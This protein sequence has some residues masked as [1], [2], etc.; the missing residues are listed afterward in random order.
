MLRQ[1]R[2]KTKY[3]LMANYISECLEKFRALPL[4]IQEAV[5][6]FEALQVIDKLEQKYDIKLGFFV[7]LVAI[8][9]L[10][11]EDIE[12]YL[13]IKYK[14]S[15]ESA[16]ELNDIMQEQIFG[17]AIE[18][19]VTDINNSSNYYKL[20]LVG[21]K[22]FL[23]DLFRTKLGTIIVLQPEIAAEINDEILEILLQDFKDNNF[24]FKSDLEKALYDNEEKFIGRQLMADGK[25]SL[26]I[27]NWLLDFVNQKGSDYFDNVILSDYLA[28]SVNARQLD[29]NDKKLLAK[30]LVLYRNLK[31]FPKSLENLPPEKW[32]II[33]IET[34]KEQPLGSNRQGAAPVRQEND[35]DL[36]Q[37]TELERK[38]I[39]EEKK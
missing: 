22:K 6:G 2:K 38:A 36:A 8:G 37:L 31:F 26:T 12:Q 15:S 25:L 9:E 7:I 19:A 14:L 23:R 3:K 4:F 34:A 29:N 21:K 5:G 30:I 35:W 16:A 10:R 11:M 20:D 18:I 24:T 17:P 27:G 32:G 13:Q 1:S 39:E 28:N 33:P